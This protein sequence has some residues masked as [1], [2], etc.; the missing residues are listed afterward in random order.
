MSEVCAD[1]IGVHK[2]QG[3]DQRGP[4]DGVSHAAA[5]STLSVA[6]GYRVLLYGTESSTARRW[7]RPCGLLSA[8]LGVELG[9]NLRHGQAHRL[10]VSQSRVAVSTVVGRRGMIVDL[11]VE[12]GH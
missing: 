1:S 2:N 8:V 6:H 10:G 3:L 9:R 12:C 4:W 7:W 11:Y 5:L